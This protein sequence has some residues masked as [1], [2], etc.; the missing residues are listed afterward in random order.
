M[1]RSRARY[2]LPGFM[3]R[4]LAVLPES[5]A[6]RAFEGGEHLRFAC[7]GCGDCCRQLRVALTHRDLDRLTRTLRFGPASLVAW[8]APDAVAPDEQRASFVLLPVGPRLMVLAHEAGACRLLSGDSHCRAYAARPLDCQL[9]PFVLERDSDQRTTRL[10]MFDPA[11]C[12]E[13]REQPE[14]LL[15]LDRLDTQ[16]WSELAEYQRVVGRWNRFARHRA[17][18]GHRAHGEAEFLGFLGSVTRAS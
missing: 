3:R 8:L 12:G 15:E 4:K 17:R 16:R 13:R 1:P 10:S 6:S 18:L 2:I 9:Y 14:S 11:G 7:N 5:G